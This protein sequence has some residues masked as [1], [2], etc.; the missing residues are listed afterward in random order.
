LTG[1]LLC[2]WRVNSE[3]DLPGLPVTNQPHTIPDI[4][5][6]IANLPERLEDIVI[7]TPFVAVSRNGSAI[8]EVQ[9]VGRYFVRGGSEIL[10]EPAVPADSPEL[11]MFLRGTP[12][13]VLCHQR[14]VIPLHASA[15]VID[16]CAVAIA[17][18]SGS[19]KSTLAAE[20]S[21]RGHAVLADDV[22]VVDVTTPEG[23][24]VLPSF[25]HIH[26]WQDAMERFRIPSG[27]ATR[28]RQ[29]IAKFQ[30]RP[31]DSILPASPVPLAAVILL[32]DDRMSAKHW[33]EHVHGFESLNLVADHVYRRRF[34]DATGRQKSLFEGSSRIAAH[35]VVR[36]L[37]VRREFAVLAAAA[38]LVEAVIRSP[39]VANVA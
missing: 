9:A 11:W 35:A 31:S 2:G 13:G 7:R 4:T 21:R 5:V 29:G 3:L 18:P 15:V 28:V 32:V 17:G 39:A 12:L 27:R 30:V 23:P 16:G 10:I 1:C 14:G 38:D 36:R 33:L 22:T 34:A 26:L 19:G 24:S 6:R 20:L 25:P 37:H 8:I